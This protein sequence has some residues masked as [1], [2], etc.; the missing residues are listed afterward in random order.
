MN[1]KPVKINFNDGL[2]FDFPEMIRIRQK[3]SKEKIIGIEEHIKKELEKISL[4]DLKNKRIA[5]TAGSRGISDI[6]IIIRV[7]IDKL[8]KQGAK[9]FIVPAMGSHGG[10]TA[11]GQ[12][13][14]L[15]SYGI[16]E[17]SMAVPVISSMDVVEIGR[18]QNGT[19]V[20]CDKNAYNADGI[21]II[22]KIKPHTDFKGEHESGILK[23]MGIGLGKHKGAMA[24]HS[25]G[26]ELFSEVLKEAAEIFIENGKILFAVGIVQNA[27]EET[28]IAEVIQ[29]DC[30]MERDK[31]LL[32]TAKK[33]IAK[34]LF[35]KID[36]LI[37]DEI[38]KNISGE[39]MDPNV[40]GRPGSGLK[41]GFEAPDIQRI[42]VRMVDKISHGNGNGIG[43]ADYTTVECVNSLDLCS[44]YTNAITANVIDTVKIPLIIDTEKNAIAAGLSTCVGTEPGKERIVRI[45]NTNELDTIYVSAQCVIDIS[46]D[47]NIEVMDRKIFFDFDENGK[48][49]N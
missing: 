33:N 5:I 27:Y 16:T 37:V 43:L 29:A 22:N 42:F 17:D 45:K 44:M 47:E 46:D 48:L 9:P 34:L 18:M 36:L 19:P 20:Y 2:S 3:F 12:L 28:M 13:E 8:K 4:Q 38:G 14:I 40:T 39:G 15:A 6:R 41:E 10:A 21:I 35:P 24:L 7:I 32:V 30:I 25:L 11:E 1:F 31:A 49:K 26:F 23:M